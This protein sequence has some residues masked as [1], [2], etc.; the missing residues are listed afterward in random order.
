MRDNILKI[1]DA[2]S[3]C[4]E[5]ANLLQ[6]NWNIK[7]HFE[8]NVTECLLMHNFVHHKHWGNVGWYTRHRKYPYTYQ[9]SESHSFCALSHIHPYPALCILSEITHP[10]PLHDNLHLQPFQHSMYSGKFEVFLKVK[11]HVYCCIYAFL[12]HLRCVKLEYH[13]YLFPN[14]CFCV[15]DKGFCCVAN[16]IFPKSPVTFITQSCTL[17]FRHTCV[18]LVE[19]EMAAQSSIPMENSSWQRSPAGYSPWGCKNLDMTE[20][21][22]THMP[23][24]TRIDRHSLQSKFWDM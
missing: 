14:F 21:T 17:I 18:I 6:H 4:F 22:H 20:H 12:N 2:V 10:L 5:Y 13:F 24:Q 8:H 7:A 9:C 11:G 3:S 19:E 15:T 1:L 23:D 16:S